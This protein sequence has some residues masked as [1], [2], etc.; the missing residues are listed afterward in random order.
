MSIGKLA[1]AVGVRDSTVRYY[2]R[3]G[4]L[5]PA[6]RTPGNYRYYHKG[7]VEQLRF[8][9]AAQASGLSLD[10]IKSLLAFRDGK[11]NPCGEVRELL[12]ARLAEVSRQMAAL[13]HVQRVLKGFL[14]AC[15]QASGADECPV[16]EELSLSA[17]KSSN[18]RK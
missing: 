8:I 9:R 13:R 5:L 10:D 3:A 18:T 4:L 11:M 15:E 7:A 2:E 17:S 6:G 16:I 12:G 1:K 14:H